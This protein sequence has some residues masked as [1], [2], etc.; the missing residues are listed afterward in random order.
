MN[1][2]IPIIV[3]IGGI[4]LFAM[5]G[6]RMAEHEQHSVISLFTAIIAVLW[7]AMRIIHKSFPQLI[8]PQTT[9]YF[10]HYAAMLAGAGITLAIIL[11]IQ[12][13]RTKTK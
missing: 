12:G 2:A 7:A 8:D 1:L 6:R 13:H 9:P 3:A 5:A 4:A 11:V 10:D